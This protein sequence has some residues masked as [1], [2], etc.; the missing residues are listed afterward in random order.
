MIKAHCEICNTEVRQVLNQPNHFCS[1]CAEFS[2]DYLLKRKDSVEKGMARLERDMETFRHK[3]LSETVI[4][5]TRKLEA[6]K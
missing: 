3:Y 5:A 1:R 2:D 4:P 6:V